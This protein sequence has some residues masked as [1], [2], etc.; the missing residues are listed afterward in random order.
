VFSFALLFV[1]VTRFVSPGH[2]VVFH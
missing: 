1:R 2:G